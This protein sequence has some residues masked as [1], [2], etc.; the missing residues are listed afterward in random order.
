MTKLHFLYLTSQYLTLS[1]DSQQ[2]IETL[3]TEQLEKIWFK[4]AWQWKVCK[5]PDF[6]NM[7]ERISWK[8]KN[9]NVPVSYCRAIIDEE[10]FTFAIAADLKQTLKNK[11]P[12]FVNEILNIAYNIFE[13]EIVF[14]ENK[15]SGRWL[16]QPGVRT[17]HPDYAYVGQNKITPNLEKSPI[18][19]IAI[20]TS[21]SHRFPLWLLS[22]EKAFISQGD[23]E[24]TRFIK[25]LQ[26]GLTQQFLEKVLIPPS[27]KFPNYRTTNFMDGHNGVYRY[28]YITQGEGNGYEPYELS[29]TMLLGWW[30]FLSDQSIK[31]IYC[32]ISSQFPFSKKEIILYS[33]PGTSRNRHPLINDESKYENGIIELIIKSACLSKN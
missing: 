30:S 7:Q 8:L 9:K 3:V 6:K 18:T 32:F 16:F 4:P 31:N 11:S 25:K 14:L 5:S 13:Q 23:L 1:N 24:K 2:E 15:P 28:N 19:E 27:N 33:G 12:E 22:L 17:D 29:G 21:H 20:D 26:K 10:L